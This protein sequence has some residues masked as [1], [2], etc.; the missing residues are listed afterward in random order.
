[1][2]TKTVSYSE[3]REKLASLM[4]EIEETLDPVIITRRGHQNMV[5]IA[6]DELSALQET[7]H[8]LRSPANAKRLLEALD[9]SHSGKRQEMTLDAL[10]QK[11]RILQA[12]R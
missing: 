7:A 9:R 11:S 12:Q 8:L 2:L 1:M 5:L 3:A 6:Q 4:D 10:E